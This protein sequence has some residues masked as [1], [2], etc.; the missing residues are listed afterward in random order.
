M[1]SY[2]PLGIRS[3]YSL[4]GSTIRISELVKQTQFES[5]AIVD[6]HNLFGAMDYNISLVASGIK[7][8]TGCNLTL[9]K[10]FNILVYCQNEMGYRALCKIITESYREDGTYVQWEDFAGYDGLLAIAIP[11]QTCALNEIEDCVIKLNRYFNSRWYVGITKR[12]EEEKYACFMSNLGN[13]PVVAVPEI[14]CASKE[15]NNAYYALTC[16]KN[17]TYFEEVETKF[18]IPTD[19]EMS[20]LYKDWTS[21][22]SNTFLFAQR[23]SFVLRPIKPELPSFS[24]DLS[25]SEYLRNL[26]YAGLKEKI[27]NVSQEYID[28]LE[29]EL[30]VINSMGFNGYFLIV[31]DFI[32]WAKQNGVSVGPGRGSGAGSLV[33]YTLHIT[34]INPLEFGLVFE[35]FLNPGRVSM[36]DFDIDFCPRGR[37]KVINYITNKYG[38][39]SVAHII[40]FGSLQSKGVLRDVGRILQIPFS[41]IDKHSKAIPVIQGHNLSLEKYIENNKE[42]ESDIANN[43]KVKQFFELS[44]QL[45]GLYRHVSIHAAGIVIGKGDLRNFLPLYKEHNLLITQFSLNHI[46]SAGL[47]KFDLLGLTALTI[48]SDTVE[49]I[50]NKNP[51]FDL[52]KISLLDD[53]TF[54]LLKHGNTVGVFQFESKGMTEVL[55]EL[56]PKNLED[57]IAVIS[58]YRPGPMEN[59][60]S[61]LKRKNGEVEIEYLF[62]EMEKTLQSTYGIFVYQEQVLEV[63]RSLAGYSMQ[64]ADLLRR[65][66][67]KKKPEEMKKH[68]TEFTKRLM[69]KMSTTKEKAIELFDQIESFAKY[70]FPKAHA[71]PYALISYQMAFLKANYPTEFIISSMI[72][73]QH[74]TEKLTEFVYEAKKLD[75]PILLPDINLSKKDFTIENGSIRFGFNAIKNVSVNCIQNI[76]DNQPFKNLQDFFKITK[77]SKKSVENLIKAGAFDSLEQNR[78]VVWNMK[79]ENLV[80]PSLFDNNCHTENWSLS[81]Q[82]QAE[83]EALGMFVRKHPLSNIQ[84]EKL[85]LDWVST[86]TNEKENISGICQLEKVIAKKSGSGDNYF[87]CIASDPMG[88]FRFI[89]SSVKNLTHLITKPIHIEGHN[90][91]KFLV[92]NKIVELSAFLQNIQ[93]LHIYINNKSELVNLK[94]ILKDH[95]ASEGTK[96]M[97]HPIDEAPI[98]VGHALVTEELLSKMNNINYKSSR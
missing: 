40:T 32:N 63:A 71:A 15:Q 91:G 14:R 34:E 61:F 79:D 70:A 12:Y 2:I 22:L 9:E 50:K 81:Q 21:P 51:E 46:E 28:R 29:F 39:Y 62:P 6:D 47:V 8:I 26:A 25:E 41:I 89:N 86:K 82:Y 17:G 84:I 76:L 92:I 55:V 10:K 1:S 16:I 59:I 97:L 19:Q 77:V 13:A 20:E 11:G 18:E 83:Y 67:G 57:L 96:L 33:A 38:Y 74:N 90:N 44:L 31:A 24:Q 52:H 88:T 65:A 49:L 72:L 45:E 43:E 42:V 35:R 93:T 60:P 37:T 98:V 66:M 87:I 30:N 5:I 48:I 4:L 27:A 80:V 68:R 53:K 7:P 75:I 73:E 95:I 64:E 23:C 36:P 85:E 58:L 3:C 56:V 78:A 54:D 94:N 69:S